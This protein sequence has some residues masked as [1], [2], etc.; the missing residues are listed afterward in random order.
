MVRAYTDRLRHFDTLKTQL[1]MI[2]ACSLVALLLVNPVAAQDV[3]AAPEGLTVM[4]FNLRVD[5]FD[6]PDLAWSLRKEG[7]A[8]AIRTNGADI[9]GTQEGTYPMIVALMELLPEYDWVGMGRNGGLSG[10]FMA[11][12]YRKDRFEV[13]DVDHF[14]LSETP[15]VPGSRLPGVGNPRM[16]TWVRFK[17]LSTGLEFSFYNSHL[18]HESQYAREFG[19]QMI[20]YH[21]ALTT[22]A[23]NLPAI[24]T[25]DMNAP[26]DNPAIHIAMGTN[27][28]SQLLYDAADFL[29]KQGGSVGATF[30]GYRG[31][32][33]GEPIDY[34]FHTADFA[35]VAF[36]V[37]RSQYGDRYP[38]DHY[39]VWV[40]F[41]PLEPRD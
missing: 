31:T 6:G 38:S 16:V 11:V 20:Y 15:D 9:V 32:I 3:S 1:M 13:I 22:R 7:A 8:E 26:P 10:E 24:L 39:P 29:R 40:R 18:D 17:D 12:I 37:E 2:I 21:V 35:P 30:H 23:W 14:W 19:A 41:A 33:E 5:G 34:V 4:S 27:I 28:D 25:A 36:G